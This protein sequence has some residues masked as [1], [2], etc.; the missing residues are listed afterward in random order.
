MPRSLRL[1]FP[2]AFYHVMA[3]GNRKEPIFE[4]DD[5]RR[6]F[7]AT[8]AEAC[9]MTGWR[10]HAWVLMGNHYHLFIETP[11]PNLVAGMKWLQNTV[12]RRHNVRHRKWGRLFGDRYKAVVVDGADTY[13]YRTLVDYIHLNP[14]RARLIQP[15]KGQSVMDFRWSSL[16]GGWSLPPR[17]RPAWLAA[18]NGFRRFGLDDTVTGRR[19]LVEALDRR[20]VEE[21]FQNC[22]VPPLPDEVDARCSHLRRGW[23]WGSREFAEK[24]G[25]LTEKSVRERDRTS[26]AYKRTPEI[27][28]H[29]DEQAERWLEEGLRAAGLTPDEVRNSSG[30]DPRKLALAELLWKRTTVSQAWI[31]ERLGMRSAANVSQQLRRHAS[32]RTNGCAIQPAALK[33]FLA[34]AWR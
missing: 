4:D 8:L 33:R 11:E 20:A 15:R 19:R 30:S 10:V 5:D 9:G 29:G 25:Q 6:F 23:F 27:V 3:R 18:A 24:L 31:A 34:R 22:G 16:A 2:G 26:R 14:V 17:S 7:L 28:A 1:E 32:E 13:H 21:E 12:T